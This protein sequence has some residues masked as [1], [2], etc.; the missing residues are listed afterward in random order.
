MKKILKNK[1]V[2]VTRERQQ[3][4]GLTAELQQYGAR[5]LLYP[6]IKIDAVADWEKCDRAI[7]ALNTYDWLVFSSVNGVR[8][9]MQR[10]GRKISAFTGRVAVTGT[11]TRDEVQKFGLSADLMPDSFSAAGLLLKFESI[12]MQNKRVLMP[13]SDIARQQLGSGLTKMGA[14]VEKLIVYQT[15]CSDD[16]NK[17]HI[18]KAIKSAEID[19]ILFFSPSAFSC[20]L[21]IFGEEIIPYIN[22]KITL[23]AIGSTTAQRIRESGLKVDVMP[24]KS[25]SEDVLHALLDYYK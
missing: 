19:A 18:L 22:E 3:S 21:N 6:T 1:T 4:A 2:L 13:V 12:D 24:Q 23:C 5:C 14:M 7:K 15:S 8:Y 17:S 10:A 20:F 11:K 25:T 9:F 16:N